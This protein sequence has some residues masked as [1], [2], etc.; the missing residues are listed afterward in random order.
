MN[1][2]I[3]KAWKTGPRLPLRP[4]G[5]CLTHSVMQERGFSLGT[6]HDFEHWASKGEQFLWKPFGLPLFWKLSWT[7][8]SLLLFRLALFEGKGHPWRFTQVFCHQWMSM[9]LRASVWKMVKGKESCTRLSR[10]KSWLFLPQPWDV[11]GLLHLTGL[12]YLS[13]QNG[14]K[15]GISPSYRVS[16]RT[17]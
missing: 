2:R 17:E 7:H 13:L 3:E 16:V 10:L 8:F 11:G 1:G 6:L 4:H 14:G 12:Q 5:V 15:K 9:L